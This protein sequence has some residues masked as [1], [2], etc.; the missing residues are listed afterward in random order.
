MQAETV[1]AGHV[2]QFGQG[3]QIGFF[4]CALFD[5]AANTNF[6]RRRIRYL[7]LNPRGRRIAR[8]AVQRV[9][10]PC[11]GHRM[12]GPLIATT[13][14]HLIE[15]FQPA[16]PI[17]AFQVDKGGVDHLFDRGIPSHFRAKAFCPQEVHAASG[18]Q[19]D[20]QAILAADNHD[21]ATFLLAAVQHFL[22][23][24]ER[25]ILHLQRLARNLPVSFL[26]A[27]FSAGQHPTLRRRLP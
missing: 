1:A 8:F 19:R 25:F 21:F 20:G 7:N 23:N 13:H 10:L 18:T 24:A 17:A 15:T 9:N 14:H 4:E 5:Q 26:H 2:A 16:E 6:I 11:V 27:I 3:L 22:L 12:T